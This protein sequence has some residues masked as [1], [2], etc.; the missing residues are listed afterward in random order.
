MLTPVHITEA[1]RLQAL[2]GPWSELL[3]RS[4][5]NEITLHPK[6]LAPWWE[7]F[8]GEGGRKLRIVAFYDGERLVG[9]A[10]F[11]SRT[12]RYRGA[13]PFRRIEILA[14]GEDAA[15][16]ICSDYLGLV[17]EKGRENEVVQATIAELETGGFEAWDELVVHAMNGDSAMPRIL[18]GALVGRDFAVSLEEYS[19]APYVPLPKTWE[20]YL[21]ALSSNKRSQLKKSL[22]NFEAW[23]GGPP[24]IVRVT[25]PE[26]LAAGKKVLHALHGERWGGGGVFGSSKFVAFH[27]RLMDALLPAGALDLGW[28]EVKGEPV[29]AFYNFCHDGRLLFYQ[30]GRKLD[31]PE[32]IRVGIT[33]HAYIM[34]GAIERGLREYDFLAGVSQYKMSLALASRPLLRLRASRRSLRELVRLGSE[35]GIA[36]AKR[37]RE[38]AGPRLK[39]VFDRLE[40]LLSSR[41]HRETEAEA[42]GA[43]QGGATKT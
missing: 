32:N 25:K 40:G 28:L 4:A 41:G 17:A 29:A 36:D 24:K 10:P 13:I 11:L 27:D 16:E 19:Q 39:P 35:R 34:Q 42:E 20:E 26:E 3:A 38:R 2:E 5:D 23:A 6:W 14:S 33:M 43:T 22:R 30:S 37:L 1:A 21:G 8:G 31:L 15:D 9:V 7:V 12:H 18:A